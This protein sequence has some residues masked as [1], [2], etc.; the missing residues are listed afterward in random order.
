[1]KY[2]GKVYAKINGRY[3]ECTQTIEQLENRIKELKAKSEE[4]GEERYEYAMKFF[5]GKL[6]WKAYDNE[7][8]LLSSVL[9]LAA[10]GKV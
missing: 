8:G 4:E 3:I 7:N 6:S 9:K 5:Y 10:F 1:M 2:K